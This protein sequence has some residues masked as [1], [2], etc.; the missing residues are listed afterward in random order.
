MSEYDFEASLGYWLTLTT[1]SYHRALAEKLSPSGITYRQMQVVG[2]LKV[3]G[4][5]SPGELARKMM[6]EPP[7]LVRIL[8]RMTAA[9]WLERREDPID[10]RR[11][12]VRLTPQVAPVWELIAECAREL[13]QMAAAGL[14]PGEVQQL[15][16]L[17][18]R[19]H[20]N[21]APAYVV[22]DAVTT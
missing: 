10:G 7:T 2:W 16:A 19:V 13:R 5:L 8:D 17:L 15:N 18:Q 9:G 21:L 14:T 20:A 22:Q 4:E 12:I 1:Q 11:R 3:H 6:I